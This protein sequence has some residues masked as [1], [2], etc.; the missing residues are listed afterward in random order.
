MNS[1]HQHIQLQYICVP[2]HAASQHTSN[3]CLHFLGKKKK[4]SFKSK[5]YKKKQKNKK[6]KKKNESK[7]IAMY[8]KT[9]ERIIKCPYNI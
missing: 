8:V 1:Y 4:K 6:Q 2:L 9:T 3:N 5:M 7:S